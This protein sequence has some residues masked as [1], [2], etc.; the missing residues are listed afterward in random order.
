VE[1]RDLSHWNVGLDESCRAAVTGGTAGYEVGRDGSTGF[2][3]IKWDSEGGVFSFTLDGE[4]PSGD[5]QVL[6]KAGTKNNTGTITGP[7]CNGYSPLA[8]YL[9]AMGKN[10]R[11]LALGIGAF[12]LLAL[13]G[14][15]GYSRIRS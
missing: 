8:A 9:G 5:V 10:N 6:A 15:Y 4:Y 3:G 12:A 13:G 1:G 7:V 11:N 14:L 2:W